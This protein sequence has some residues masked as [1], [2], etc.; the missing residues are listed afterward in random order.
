[1]SG[2]PADSRSAGS[3]LS[4]LVSTHQR[5]QLE[6]LSLREEPVDTEEGGAYSDDEELEDEDEEYLLRNATPYEDSCSSESSTRVLCEV[7]ALSDFVA[8]EDK[9][10]G[11][12]DREIL[13]IMET[14]FVDGWLL[15]QNALGERGYIPSNYVQRLPFSDKTARA[16]SPAG[17]TSIAPKNSR[18][19]WAKLK[20]TVTQTSLA[21]VLNAL[22]A[23]PSGFRDSTLSKL[24]SSSRNY[25]CSTSATPKLSVTGMAFKDLHW[26]FVQDQLQP[27]ATKVSR[28]FSVLAAKSIP[29][30]GKG[31]KVLSRH[32]RVAVF[33]K[34]DVLSNI[35]TVRAVWLPTE[36]R[37]W[38][39]S[40]RAQSST[41]S[42]L[43][44][45]G[46]VRMNSEDTNI[47][48]LFEL[49][50]TFQREKTGEV[51]EI[52]CGWSSLPLYEATGNP[53]PNKTY[54][55]KVHGGTPFESDVELDPARNIKSSGG[56]IPAIL[57]T[58]QTPRLYVRLLNVPRARKAVYDL[59]PPRIVTS[60]LYAQ[61][62]GFFRHL[63]GVAF[64]RGRHGLPLE[65]CITKP[66]L[67]VFLW[68]IDQPDVIDATLALFSERM[69]L[70]KRADKTNLKYK[71]EQLECVLLQ[72][73]YPLL[74]LNKFPKQI[75]ADDSQ[76]KERMR[77]IEEISKKAHLAALVSAECVQNSVD[78]SE[79]F[80]IIPYP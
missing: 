34:N 80:F 2:W 47:E 14:S 41:D 5:K 60:A 74:S 32:V 49:G 53:T 62:L 58:N 66:S 42:L 65:S 70:A 21:D 16:A 55:L 22:G 26:D 23:I 3:K 64:L 67:N 40:P 29:L 38:K 7:Q 79:Q 73:I 39:F 15:A 8:I 61:L 4:Q 46:V 78:I 9:D 6:D 71:T 13:V 24:L 50:V 77:F 48:L 75:W 72:K 33:N 69:R 36:E 31:V 59:I 63:V 1:M 19:L 56:F 54:E 20:A 52:S 28:E 35:H 18:D 76:E 68:A 17:G 45:V 27:K 43:H 10:L 51:G 11:F 25:L 57:R 37:S 12:K 44:P 30:P